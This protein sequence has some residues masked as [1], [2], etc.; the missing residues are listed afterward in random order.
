MPGCGHPVPMPSHIDACVGQWK[1]AID[2]NKATVDADDK[3][4]A[5]T[6]NN[7]AWHADKIYE[8][9]MSK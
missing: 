6:G 5:I 3:Y 2:C 7:S 1:K 9:Q 8:N 4:V